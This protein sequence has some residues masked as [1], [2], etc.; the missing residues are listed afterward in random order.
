LHVCFQSGQLLIY[1]DAK[2]ESISEEEI[3]QALTETCQDV[4][5]QVRPDVMKLF[6][7]A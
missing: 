3:S 6:E 1:D 7:E 4:F 5:N 2:Y